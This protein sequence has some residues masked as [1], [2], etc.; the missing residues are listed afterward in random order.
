MLRSDLEENVGQRTS[1]EPKTAQGI[2]NG[3]AQLAS[4]GVMTRNN[5]SPP[6]PPG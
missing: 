1:V 2:S 4:E 3:V 5:P 6:S